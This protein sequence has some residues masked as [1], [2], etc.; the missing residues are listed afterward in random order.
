MNLLKFELG[1]K[2]DKSDYVPSK[3]SV[4]IE[5]VT[6]QP[7]PPPP[8]VVVDSFKLP[9]DFGQ[10]MEDI[11]KIMAMLQDLKN[12]FGIVRFFGIF[13]VCFSYI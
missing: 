9:D 7:A 2:L 8:P 1:N 5:R 3:E 10:K 4:V 6:T 12:N 11:R 13:F